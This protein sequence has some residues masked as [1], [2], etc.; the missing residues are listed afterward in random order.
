MVVAPS[1]PVCSIGEKPKPTPLG[2]KKVRDGVFEVERDKL[3]ALGVYLAEDQKWDAEAQ[4]CMK[5]GAKLPEA[6]TP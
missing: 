6:S 3:E 5:L 2:A 1:P 4:T